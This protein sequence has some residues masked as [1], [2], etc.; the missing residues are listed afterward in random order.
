MENHLSVPLDNLTLTIAKGLQKNGF[1]LKLFDPEENLI[2]VAIASE[3]GLSMTDQE[4]RDRIIGYENNPDALLKLL[5]PWRN[6]T[7]S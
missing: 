5:E 6:R 7:A 2:G 4:V 1:I 3:T